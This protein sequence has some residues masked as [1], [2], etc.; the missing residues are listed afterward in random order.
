MSILSKIFL[1]QTIPHQKKNAEPSIVNYL[2]TPTPSTNEA[3]WRCCEPTCLS[4]SA[5]SG[6]QVGTAQTLVGK[7]HVK[8]WVLMIET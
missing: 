7:T 4:A 2:S 8:S 1:N 6:V 5:Q 3:T